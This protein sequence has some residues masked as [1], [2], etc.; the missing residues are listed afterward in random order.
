MRRGRAGGRSAAAGLLR[1]FTWGMLALWAN[2][3]VRQASRDGWLASSGHINRQRP[4]VRQRG[5]LNKGP[6]P[7]RML[8][9][10]LT[11]LTSSATNGKVELCKSKSAA[12]KAQASRAAQKETSVESQKAQNRKLRK[13]KIHHRMCVASWQLLGCMQRRKNIYE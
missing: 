1:W 3:S 4:A 12:Q 6:G 10:P 7:Q 8:P 9:A 5:E 11:E 2:H 13:A